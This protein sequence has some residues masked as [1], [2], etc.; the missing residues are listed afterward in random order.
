MIFFSFRIDDSLVTF[1]K[2]I[3]V[4]IGAFFDET[5]NPGLDPSLFEQVENMDFNSALDMTGLTDIQKA[6]MDEWETK[7]IIPEQFAFQ[8]VVS[9]DG[10]RKLADESHTLQDYLDENP[11]VLP[12]YYPVEEDF[13]YDTED[14]F[15]ESS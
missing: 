5:S 11:E 15:R 9:S 8:S 2:A 12:Y 7:F 10:K 4:A 1:S 13:D 6:K 14:I 3:N